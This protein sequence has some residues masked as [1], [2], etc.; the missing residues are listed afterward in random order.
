[1]GHLN[2]S[3]G[4]LHNPCPSGVDP[5]SIKT[6]CVSVLVSMHFL[7]ICFKNLMHTST[8]LLLWWWYDDTAA[9]PMFSFLQNSLTVIK[10]QWLNL[11]Q[12]CRFMR[13][14]VHV[15]VCLLATEL[16]NSH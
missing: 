11:L 1:M 14:C 12:L 4:G 15:S 3:V 8:C 6:I 5:I 2:N 10:Q 13:V 16:L 9:C 7:S